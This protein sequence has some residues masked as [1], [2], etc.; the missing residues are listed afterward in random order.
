M[1]SFY[2]FSTDKR[3]YHLVEYVF[4]YDPEVYKD[5]QTVLAALPKNEDPESFGYKYKIIDLEL[6]DYLFD[7]KLGE[8][9]LTKAVNYS[10]TFK[11]IIG[12]KPYSIYL[13]F[14]N[15]DEN[16]YLRDAFGTGT[17]MR[18][19][20]A[21]GTQTMIASAAYKMYV[22]GNT[23][24]TNVAKINALQ[25]RLDKIYGK[26]KVTVKEATLLDTYL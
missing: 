15:G 16:V 24:D 20:V 2:D 9:N 11:K 22:P 25:T 4:N 26:G 7:Y 13:S 21:Y 5:A 6:M 19:D 1:I 23:A 14:G 17:L 10:G 3:E 12:D 8:D 18:D